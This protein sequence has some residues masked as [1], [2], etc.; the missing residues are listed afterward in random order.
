MSW[1][2]RELEASLD[3]DPISKKIK[4]SLLGLTHVWR[5]KAFLFAFAIWFPQVSIKLTNRKKSEVLA[6][7][8]TI[9]TYLVI[10]WA[11][12]ARCFCLFVCSLFFETGFLCV[13]LAVLE[14]TL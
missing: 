2:Q 13:A 7:K 6:T 11:F 1:L 12:N 5:R 4:K 8:Q 14:L 3:W 9:Y 10:R